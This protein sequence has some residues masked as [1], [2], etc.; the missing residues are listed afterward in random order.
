MEFFFFFQFYAPWCGHCKKLEPTFHEVSVELRDS[1]IKVAKLDCTRYSSVAS[2]FGVRGFPTIK[3]ISGDNEFTHKGERSKE[4]ILEFANRAFGPPVRKI[5]SIGKFYDVKGKIADSVMFLYVGD[6][7][8]EA[9]LFQKYSEVAEKS[10]IQAYFYAGKRNILP[11]D[12]KFKNEPTVLVFK[13]G[14]TYEYEAPDGIPT[15]TSLQN[16]VRGERYNA[17][18]L[19]QGGNINEMADT[20]KILV[21]AVVDFNDE[22]KS[23]LNAR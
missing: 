11:Q 9:D 19:V 4:D 21:I 7:D 22:E 14:E 2:E 6:D 16:W 15:M 13:D 3:F 17:F 18:P 1:Q 20:E 10:R 23:T 8:K 12:I 5:P